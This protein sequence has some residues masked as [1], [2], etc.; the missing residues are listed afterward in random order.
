MAMRPTARAGEDENADAGQ[1]HGDDPGSQQNYQPCRAPGRDWPARGGRQVSRQLGRLGLGSRG[2]GTVHD[3]PMPERNTRAAAP[4]GGC[5][6]APSVFL[7][8]QVKGTFF[9]M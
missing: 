2:R 3:T 7:S 1:R 9:N 6:T 4:S 5:G 8:F